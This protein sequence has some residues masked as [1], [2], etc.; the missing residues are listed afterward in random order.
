MILLCPLFCLRRFMNVIPPSPNLLAKYN[1][2]LEKWS[3][4]VMVL[5]QNEANEGIPKWV[6]KWPRVH[7]V[8]GPLVTWMPLIMVA[9]TIVGV[10]LTVNGSIVGAIIALCCFGGAI[11]SLPF[12]ETNEQHWCDVKYDWDTWQK[13]VDN[14]IK[15]L[16][17]SPLQHGSIEQALVHIAKLRTELFNSYQKIEI[18][19]LVFD[20]QKIADDYQKENDEYTSNAIAASQHNTVTVQTPSILDNFGQGTIDT[21]LHREQHS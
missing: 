10:S 16:K 19:N 18:D 2:L 17:N 4:K 5:A 8:V 15:V 14:V 9:G 6:K 11:F 3:N 1:L 12:I 21:Q 7:K 13:K 20:L